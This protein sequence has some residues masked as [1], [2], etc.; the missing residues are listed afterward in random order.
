MDLHDSRQ[1]VYLFAWVKGENAEALTL[2]HA[3]RLTEAE[4]HLVVR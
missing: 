2:M 1:Y 3:R 4:G